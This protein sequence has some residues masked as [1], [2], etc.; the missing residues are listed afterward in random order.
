M[1][2]H[3]FTSDDMPILRII[4]DLIP[5]LRKKGDKYPHD[6]W[7]LRDRIIN[8]VEKRCREILNP[9]TRSATDIEALRLAGSDIKQL[10]FKKLC[11]NADKLEADAKSHHD[12]L[13][14][15]YWE[16]K[17]LA[18]VGVPEPKD[19]V[20]NPAAEKAYDEALR[21]IIEF[22]R[23]ETVE[24]VIGNREKLDNMFIDAQSDRAKP[25]PT[26]FVQTGSGYT[27][28]EPEE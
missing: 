27:E 23:P 26:S 21:M 3:K 2:K 17:N 25:K 15:T 10:T 14:H 16:I 6:Q 11:R 20:Y 1:S 5:D 4:A 12:S 24:T 18:S 22:Y 19:G 28:E 13:F 7:V 8:H 9:D